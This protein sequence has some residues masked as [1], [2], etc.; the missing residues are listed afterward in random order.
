MTSEHGTSVA[1]CS[2]LCAIPWFFCIIIISRQPIGLGREIIKCPMSVCLY[3][4]LSRYVINFI[5]P[6]FRNINYT[7]GMCQQRHVFHSFWPHSEKQD[8]RQ[9]RLSIYFLHLSKPSYSACVIVLVLN[10]SG[11]IDYYK[12]LLGGCFWRVRA[13]VCTGIAA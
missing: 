5:N 3:V 2:F 7:K 1:N 10:F 6:L 9:S 13:C 12:R 4:C 11:E 8:G